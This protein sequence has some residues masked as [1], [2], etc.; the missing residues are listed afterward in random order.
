M[1]GREGA[2][3]RAHE[4]HVVAVAQHRAGGAGTGLQTPSTQATAPTV[5]RVPSI[6]DA[7]NS[8]P[9]SSVSAAPRPALKIGSSSYTSATAAST[10][11]IA[12]PPAAS[13]A[14]P[15]SRRRPPRRSACAPAARGRWG[16]GPRPRARR[17][18]P[19]PSPPDDSENVTTLV[20]WR[21]DALRESCC[22][23]RLRGPL[24]PPL[25]QAIRL[26]TCT[27]SSPAN[28]RRGLRGCGCTRPKYRLNIGWPQR[29]GFAILHVRVVIIGR[30]RSWTS[31]P[32][33]R[34]RSTNV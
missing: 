28:P 21:P 27:C 19:R 17:S 11:S 9:P 3:R 8:T 24:P 16:C 30:T 7:S 15:A 29:R 18:L 14:W 25:G 23:W 31:A 32:R 33:P 4:Q 20:G 13:T 10:A 2:R 22:C 1:V 5:R 26:G 12:L 34:R 6:T